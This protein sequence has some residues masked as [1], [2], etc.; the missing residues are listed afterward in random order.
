MVA[1]KAS[2]GE[3]LPPSEGPGVQ[4]GAMLPTFQMRRCRRENESRHEK[5]PQESIKLAT[6]PAENTGSPGNRKVLTL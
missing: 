6:T 5:G 1:F 4:N 2:P 3:I